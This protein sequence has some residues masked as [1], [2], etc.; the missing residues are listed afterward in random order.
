LF[1]ILH[2]SV[3]PSYIMSIVLANQVALCQVLTLSSYLFS[4]KL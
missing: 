3:V 4:H 1:T 2:D